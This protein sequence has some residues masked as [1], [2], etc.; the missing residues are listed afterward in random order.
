ME[1]GG[2]PIAAAGEVPRL[3]PDMASRRLQVLA[4]VRSYIS[5]MNGSPSLGEIAAG[6]DIS[7]TR[8]RELVKA[9][10][11]EGQ[12]LRRPGPRGLMLPSAIDE[13]KRQLRE[14]GWQIDE[15]FVCASAPVPPGGAHSTLHGPPMLDYLPPDGEGEDGE[16]RGDEAGGACST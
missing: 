16:D 10:V 7:R 14:L 2:R 12:L 8:A 13:A 1:D 5:R 3:R 6:I 15:A 9:L 4:F 11:R